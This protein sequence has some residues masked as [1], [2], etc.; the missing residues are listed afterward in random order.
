MSTHELRRRSLN[1]RRF[2]ALGASALAAPAFL[3]FG[4]SVSA[5]DEKPGTIKLDYAYYSPTSLVLRRFAWLEEELGAEDIQIEWTL[6]AGSNKANEYLRSDAIDFGS[7]AGAAALLARAN[8][9]NI[10]T[11]YVY[12]KPEWAALVAPAGS[13][14]STVEQLEGKKVA[15][16]K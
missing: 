2:A 16:T 12:S 4:R 11:V 10:R 14:I 6:S 7:T 1:R 13:E 3:R 9:S 15:A 5:Q 8:G